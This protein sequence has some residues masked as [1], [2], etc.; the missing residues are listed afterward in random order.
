M[1]FRPAPMILMR[2]PL[3]RPIRKVGAPVGVITALAIITGLLVLLMTAANPVGAS[4]GFVLSSTMTLGVVLAYLWLD[5]WEPEPPRL[6]LLAFVWGSSVAVLLSLGLELLGNVVFGGAPLVSK[7]F[8]TAVIRAPIIE[9]AAKGLFL[10]LMLTGRRR[11][12]LN[13]LTDC[14][15]YAG[16]TAAGF[17][18]LE[19]IEYIA[20]AESPTTTAATA[21]LR[22]V[23]APFAHPLFTTMTGFGVYFSL[24]LRGPA[25]KA[26]VILAGY[27]AA[28]AMHAL[29]NGSLL[30]GVESY[31]LIYLFW[32]A[33][34]FTLVVVVGVRSRRREQRIVAEKLPGMVAAGLI[35]PNEATWLGSLHN[36][37]QAIREAS[38]IGGRGV[39]KAVA[40]FAAAVVEL[41]FVRDRIDSSLAD[42]RVFELQQQGV[43]A[44]AEARWS[45]PVLR[46]L[47]H[48]RA[49]DAPARYPPPS[50]WPR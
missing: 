40:G 7:L 14:M 38:R 1:M 26:G 2:P 33:P 6:L 36:R 28:V 17:S 44:V 25:G 29:W 42:Q 46:W 13:S 47:A 3:P 12:E 23:L 16:I 32:M 50:R 24:R 10:L 48:Y 21:V 9:E 30:G 11:N 18:W 37:K 49:P 8:D 27:L 41:A 35:T 4:I 19:D 45:A 22:L 43:R 34:V 5:R 20:G 31:F 15:V 39:G